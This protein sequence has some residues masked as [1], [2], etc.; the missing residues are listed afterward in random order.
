MRIFEKLYTRFATEIDF[1][2]VDVDA[3]PEAAE[4]RGIEA[5]PTF[6]VFRKGYFVEAM[7]GAEEEKLEDLVQRHIAHTA[8]LAAEAIHASPKPSP[9]LRMNS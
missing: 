4:Q 3:N 9:H 7:R 5:V 6:E 1:V 2:V 8:E